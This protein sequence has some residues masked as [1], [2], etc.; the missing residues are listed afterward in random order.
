MKKFVFKKREY[1]RL[2][3][4][5]LK[6][7]HEKHVKAAREAFKP[8]VERLDK[9]CDASR[10]LTNPRLDG[11]LFTALQL[12]KISSISIANI[13]PE[14]KIYKRQTDLIFDI[15]KPLVFRVNNSKFKK[16]YSNALALKSLSM[17]WAHLVKDIA[18]A[19]QS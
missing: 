3:K 9:K 14:E 19:R 17:L 8:A 11:T 15:G 10:I 16:K 6:G 18:S 12:I 13:D 5:I 1:G 4:W 7:I 2:A